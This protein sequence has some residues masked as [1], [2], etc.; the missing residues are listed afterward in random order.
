MEPPVK[1]RRRYHSPQ[2]R[3]QALATR[4]QVAEAA[5]RLFARDGYFGTS[6]EAIAREAGVAVP[7]VYAVFGTKGAILSDLVD[8]AIFGRDAPGTPA[9]ERTWYA[10]LAHEPNSTRLLRHWGEYVCEVMARV[11][12][13]QRVVRSATDS[14][15]DIAQLWQRMKDQRLTGQAAVAQLLADRHAL[16]PGL[17]V[18]Q[19]ADI[20]YV[21]CDAALYDTFVLDRGWSPRQLARWLG[22]TF[23]ALLLP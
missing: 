4:R 12:P 16:R 15:P 5:G 9:I 8:D 23:C 11:A 19:A 18:G 20:I 21:L 22:D 13:V 17:T 7:T 2:R 1:P 14:D 3:Q 6:V 10:E